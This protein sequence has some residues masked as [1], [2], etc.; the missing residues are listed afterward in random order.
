VNPPGSTTTNGLLA[1]LRR[2]TGKPDIVWSCP[3]APVAGG[4]W[5]E[6]HVIELA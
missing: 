4:F 1:A 3:P 2:Q 6:M 5:A